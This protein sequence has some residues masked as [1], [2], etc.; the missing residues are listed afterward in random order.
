M[1][2]MIAKS[3]T[4]DEHLDH[5]RKKFAWLQKYKLR[6][7]PAKCT[8]RVRSGKLM[9]FIVSQKGIEVDP[10]K[11]R[12]IQDMPPPKTEKEVWGFLDRLKY[13]SRFISH[14]MAT[15]ETIFKLL[16]EN[17]MIMWNDDY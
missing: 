9:G 2:N 1:D 16:R 12:T 3:K 6:L 4:K 14:L 11:V 13:I 10:D 15:Y 8:F 17:Q 7:N 5:L